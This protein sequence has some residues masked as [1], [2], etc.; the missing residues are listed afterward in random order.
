MSSVADVQHVAKAW[1]Q[2]AVVLGYDVDG[3]PRLWTDKARFMQGIVLGVTG[4]GKTTLPRNMS[5]QDLQCRVGP[6]GDRHKIP[7]VTATTPK[8]A[9]HPAVSAAQYS[10]LA[11]QGGCRADNDMV[12]RSVPVAESGEHRLGQ[13]TSASCTSRRCRYC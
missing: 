9:S 10:P 8:P 6:E 2:N 13:A 3:A 1:E 4:S 12:R 5:T 11:G 7:M